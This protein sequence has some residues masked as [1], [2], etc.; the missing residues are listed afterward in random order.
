[1]DNHSLLPTPNARSI[2]YVFASL[3]LIIIGLMYFASILKPL[4]IAFLI[5][6]IINQ[7]KQFLGNI[8]IRGK[9]LPSIFRSI[10]AFVIIF[11][12]IYLIAELLIINIEGIVASVPEYIEGLN[13]SFARVSAIIDNPSYTEYLQKWI[14]DLYL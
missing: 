7:L 9:A 2:F 10:L 8:T 5:W 13:N 6:F 3:T 1:M 12:I 14:N 4:V 11:L